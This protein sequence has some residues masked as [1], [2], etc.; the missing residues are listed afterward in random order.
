MGEGAVSFLQGVSRWLPRLG[1]V[2]DPARDGPPVAERPDVAPL[3]LAPL[4]VEPLGVEPLGVASLGV[5][6]LVTGRAA[7]AC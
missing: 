5:A 7:R 3:A 2:L 6:S 1:N 4:V